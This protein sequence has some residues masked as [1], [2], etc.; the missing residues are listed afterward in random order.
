MHILK[1]CCVKLREKTFILDFQ[2]PCLR[3][4]HEKEK[5]F[6]RSSSV[7]GPKFLQKYNFLYSG[8]FIVK[9]YLN[10]CRFF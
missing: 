9:A 2:N 1:S 3:L 6:T 10:S 4:N 5:S 8:I 7:H